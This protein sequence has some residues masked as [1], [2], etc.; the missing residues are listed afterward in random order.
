MIDDAKVFHVAQATPV[1]MG[2][3]PSEAGAS[4][5]YSS[6][7][8]S[9]PGSASPL[10]KTAIVKNAGERERERRTDGQTVKTERERERNPSK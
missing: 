5:D 9:L 10:T 1:Y 4:D 3:V 8:S 6:L 7:T 2:A